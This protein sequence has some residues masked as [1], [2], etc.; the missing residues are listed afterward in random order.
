MFAIVSI[1]LEITEQMSKEAKSQ[2]EIAYNSLSKYV[3]KTIKKSLK[4][5]PIIDKEKIQKQI[6]GSFDAVVDLKEWDSYIP[7]HPAV[8]EILK[9]IKETNNDEDKEV[10]GHINS[11]LVGKA[12]DDGDYKV[13][14]EWWTS[15]KQYKERIDYLE[16]IEGLRKDE[17]NIPNNKPLYKYYVDNN[18]IVDIPTDTL[19]LMDDQVRISYPV[20]GFVLQFQNLSRTIV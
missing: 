3:L 6:S 4:E 20:N 17:F 2:K 14:N 16:Y 13:F 5:Y 8:R 18:V 12:Q 19:K 9:Q 15:Q 10:V 11:D 7:H 1:A